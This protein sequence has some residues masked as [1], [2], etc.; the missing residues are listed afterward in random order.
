MAVQIKVEELENC[1]GYFEWMMGKIHGE[2]NSDGAPIREQEKNGKNRP[3]SALEG[4]KV[5]ENP[6]RSGA[7]APLEDVAWVMFGTDFICC[8]GIKEDEIRTTD[9][10]ELRRRY[11][12]EVGEA[13]GRNEHDTDRIWKSVHGKCSVLEL[14]LSLCFRL[15]EMVNE[16]EPGTMIPAFFDL[17]T[18]NLGFV[19]SERG[20]YGAAYEDDVKGW[21]R[22][23]DRMMK[24]EYQEDGSDG[25]LFPLKKWST[26]RGDKD[27]RKV[28]IWYQMNSWLS[29]NLD[30][31]EHFIL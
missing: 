26:E 7:G 23:I 14:I 22:K 20:G 13:Y 5:V 21:K 6:G 29:E 27:Q 10:M 30:E 15:D 11:A 24:R 4:K 16:D 3:E 18:G 12:D 28:P 8:E 9:A 1:P 19:F 31:D 25:G 2:G 17:L